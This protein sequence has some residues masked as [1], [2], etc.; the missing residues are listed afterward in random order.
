MLTKLQQDQLCYFNQNASLDW[1]YY[2]MFNFYFMELFNA[3]YK[4]FPTNNLIWTS[5]PS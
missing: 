1:R 5:V 4:Y 2:D 3:I